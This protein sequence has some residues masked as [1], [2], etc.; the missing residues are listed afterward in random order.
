MM[1]TKPDS[2]CAEAADEI[3]RL[4]SHN[5]ALIETVRASLCP[6]NGRATGV[7]VAECQQCGCTSGLMVREGRDGE[8]PLAAG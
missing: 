3:E 4:R 1:G 8:S 7:I 2:D 6:Y 5:A